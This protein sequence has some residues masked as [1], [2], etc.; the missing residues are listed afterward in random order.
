M[1]DF[2]SRAAEIGV[3]VSDIIAD[4]T[5][6]RV[7]TDNKPSERNGWYY[8]VNIGDRLFATIGNWETG[9]QIKFPGNGAEK[10]LSSADL[11]ALALM[12]NEAKKRR[13]ECNLL[14]SVMSEYIYNNAEIC[15]HDYLDN[16]RIRPHAAR[17][18]GGELLI[19]IYDQEGRFSTLQRIFPSGEKKL[20]FGGKKKGCCHIIDGDND[21]VYICEGFATGATINELTGCKV[22]VAIDAGN[23]Q[24]V[25]EFAATIY[26]N[27]VIAS[28][29]DHKKEK[30]VGLQTG[31]RI[32]ENIGCHH[33]YP[34]GIEGSDFN[35][36][37]C[38]VGEKKTLAA[39][40]PGK[41]RFMTVEDLSCNDT[42]MSTPLTD[43]MLYPGGIFNDGMNGLSQPGMPN[44]PQYS[45]PVVCA[46]IANALAGKITCKGTWPNIFAVKV[47]PTSSG[48]SV[49]DREMYNS[50]KNV[51]ISGFYGMTDI[52]SG[53]GLYRGISEKP[54]TILAI[55][56]VTSIFK[57]YSNNDPIAD[58]KRDALL[59]IYSKSGGYINKSFGNAKN[60]IVVDSPCLTFTGNA[61][62][63]IFD[64]ITLSDFT[65][66]FIPRID[67]FVY[68]GKVPYRG[69]R[70]DSNAI[71]DSFALGVK[72]ITNSVLGDLHHVTN[73]PKDIGMTSHCLS[74]YEQMSRET[75][76][77]INDNSEGDGAGG[78]IS[79]AFDMAVKYALIHIGGTRPANKIYEPMEF[80][81]LQWGYSVAKMLSL[82]KVRTLI[83]SI[84]TGEFHHDCELFKKAIAQATLT[85]Q[86]PTFGLMANRQKALKN[87]Q[88]KYS[89]SIIEIL[90]KRGEI[91][92]DESKS[93]TAYRLVK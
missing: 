51:G 4:S 90:V 91:Y 88:R 79:R 89:K 63:V 71:L 35:D 33:V 70:E 60:S 75:T 1:N 23:M 44:I 74:L 29:N 80:I 76:D 93:V 18:S 26:K 77:A 46:V 45:F 8:A 11:A 40:Q 25:A 2:I 14:A 21:I 47:G 38:E 9:D 22:L 85:G 48:K 10:G 65:T 12:R 27:I 41:L 64:A 3:V 20:Y 49:S 39:L 28:D 59:D 57:K 92:L 84:T 17:V 61:T 13:E 83:N 72:A 62:P 78:V 68:D 36:M 82:W 69:V 6:Q 32:S 73:Q 7:P 86:R 81:D 66:G 58:S 15:G 42:K 16:K 52:A 37:F 30:N 67:F 24:P 5:C 31:K 50:L 43:E 56:E 19:P 55:D 34:E 87:W 54:I 53:A